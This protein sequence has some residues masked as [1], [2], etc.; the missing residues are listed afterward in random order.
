[1]LNLKE[2]LILICP[3][4]R[5]KIGTNT[6]LKAVCASCGIEFPRISGVP[7]LRTVRATEEID[8]TSGDLP[9]MNTSELPIPLLIEA[10]SSNG[11]I[12]EI[13]AGID[14]CPSG[15]LV[16]TDAYLYSDKLDYLVDAHCLP[17]PDN[18]FDYVY[19][20]AVFEHIHSPW[21]V[22]DEIFRVLK[23]GGK[24]YTLVAF[25]QHVHGYPSH[26][27]NMTDMGLRHLFGQFEVL[28]CGP[29]PFCPLDQ[30]CYCLAD[31]NEMVQHLRSA[32]KKDWWQ[33]GSD[34]DKLQT[35]IKGVI[36]LLPKVQ[37][38]LI[39]LPAT[40]DAWKRI[41]TGFEI[42]AMKPQKIS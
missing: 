25:L 9:T 1:M 34:V 6:N 16:K 42:T 5:A 7:I 38:E 27:F 40:H 37:N 3:S 8:Y 2:S 17:F 19:S 11:L 12:L 33:G 32:Q 30:I 18:T 22:A 23:P 26:F 24:V 36:E 31:L 10:F 13:G 41:A 35:A 29:S 15:N 14:T 39:S 28:E 21:I 20:L 4:C